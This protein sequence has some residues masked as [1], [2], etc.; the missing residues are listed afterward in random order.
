MKRVIIL[1]GPEGAGRTTIGAPAQEALCIPF[2]RVEPL[3]L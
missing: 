2:L 1:V 3:F